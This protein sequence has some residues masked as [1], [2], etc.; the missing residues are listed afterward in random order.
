ML[1]RLSSAGTGASVLE[2]GLSMQEGLWSNQ[3]HS[4]RART[5]SAYLFAK[6]FFQW[7]D[8]Q[9]AGPVKASA[10]LQSLL[11]NRVGYLPSSWA[12]L[13]PSRLP[14]KIQEKKML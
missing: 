9:V 12:V 1:V 14:I 5:V 2:M 8:F 3:H 13:A 7:I 10:S 11:E 6:H 4:N